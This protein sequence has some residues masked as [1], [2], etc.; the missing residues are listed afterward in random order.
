MTRSLERLVLDTSVLIEYIIANSPYRELIKKWFRES[1]E[2]RIKLYVNTLTLAETLY[3]ASRIYRATGLDIDR[4][5]SEAVRFIAYITTRV[6]VI[7]LDEEIAVKAGELKK[8]LHLAL[9][10]CTVLAT[11]LKLK[12]KPVFKRIEKEMKHIKEELRKLDTIFL[13]EVART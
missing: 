13:E 5:N 12:A 9:P 6:E 4:A 8:K 1:I 11:A 2:D 10:D 3:V 7:Q